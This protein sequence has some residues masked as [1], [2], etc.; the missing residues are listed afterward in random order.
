MS[1][2]DD[3]DSERGGWGDRAGDPRDRPSA[4]VVP[5]TAEIVLVMVL[6]PANLA[7]TAL[8]AVALWFRQLGVAACG[9]DHPCDLD[10]LPW[11]I[12]VPLVV[13]IVAVAAIAVLA[14]IVGGRGRRIGWIAVLATLLC[15]V[16]I[17]SGIALSVT[18]IG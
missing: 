18:A 1:L 2:R 13:G 17:L 14:P 7:A 3:L 15:A 5:A 8:A 4:A 11:S 16:G 10:L 6:A 12:G 9:P